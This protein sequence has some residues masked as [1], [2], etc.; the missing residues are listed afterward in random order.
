MIGPCFKINNVTIEFYLDTKTK[1]W[2]I[3]R[4][5]TQPTLILSKAKG[6]AVIKFLELFVK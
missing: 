3:G 1:Q 2:K 5:Y 6:D 4:N